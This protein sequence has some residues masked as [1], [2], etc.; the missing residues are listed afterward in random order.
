MS[1]QCSM[2]KKKT[3]AKQPSKHGKQKPVH[4][5]GLQFEGVDNTRFSFAKPSTIDDLDF[6]HI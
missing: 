5:S 6:W 3:R 1:V 4:K 2:R